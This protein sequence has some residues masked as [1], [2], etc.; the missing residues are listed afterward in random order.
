[1][2]DQS[3][4]ELNWQPTIL[5]N[6]SGDSHYSTSQE[7]FVNRMYLAVHPDGV[8]G[9]AWDVLPEDRIFPQAQLVG[10]KPQRDV[11]FE[12]PIRFERQGAPH[13]SSIIPNGTWVLPY[14]DST[15]L[16]FAELKTMQ[17]QI[18]HLI[19]SVLSEVVRN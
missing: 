18:T 9:V 4:A 11:P 19:Q 17:Q 3:L 15:Y 13:V 1:M 14:R 7:L 12:L 8:I 10:W 6:V 5:V 16:L 2:H